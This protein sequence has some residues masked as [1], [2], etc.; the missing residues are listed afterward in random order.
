MEDNEVNAELLLI[1]LDELGYTADVVENGQEFLDAMKRKHYDLVLMDC[2]M[3]IL[4]GYDAT[5][6]YRSKENND[7]HTPI[8]AITANVMTGDRE[9]CLASGMDDYIAKPVNPRTLRDKL[10]YWFNNQ[11]KSPS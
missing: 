8:I 4:N 5:E 1:H 3:P 2:Q 6:Q 11:K 7:S 9:K 10:Q